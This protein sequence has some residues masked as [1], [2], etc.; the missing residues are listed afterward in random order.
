MKSETQAKE[1]LTGETQRASDSSPSLGSAFAEIPAGAKLQ[2]GDQ[3]RWD[4]EWRDVCQNFRL[5]EEL[6]I[7]PWPTVTKG[8]RYR[9]PN[10]RRELPTPN[11]S[12]GT[13][14]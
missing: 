1:D 7:L 4:G 2:P 8:I 3:V 14:A 13:T 10:A 9:R 12:K 6:C 5:I 11:N